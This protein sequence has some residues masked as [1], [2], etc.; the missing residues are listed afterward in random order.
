VEEGGEGDSA[1]SDKASVVVEHQNVDGRA[2]GVVAY[3][4]VPRG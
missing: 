3:L 4:H 1:M 2:I